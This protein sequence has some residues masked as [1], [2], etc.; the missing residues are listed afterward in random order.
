MVG[1]IKWRSLR[2]RSGVPARLDDVGVRRR[3][4][5]TGCAARG[6]AGAGGAWRGGAWR[7][8]GGGTA[9]QGGGSWLVCLAEQWVWLGGVVYRRARLSTSRRR[10]LE[11]TFS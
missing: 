10:L 7:S 5:E 4:H 6:G 2:P 3:Q 8:G 11:Y 9:V 1:P